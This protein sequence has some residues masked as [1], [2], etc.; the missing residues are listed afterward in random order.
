M[1]RIGSQGY[2][3]AYAYAGATSG[4]TGTTA[5]QTQAKAAEAAKSG[6]SVSVT[7]SAEAQAALAAAGSDGRS[8]STV[9]S[10]ARKSLD[11]LLSAAKATSALKDGKATIDVSGLD[12]R[13][14]Y[15]IAS[16]Q[17]GGFP[18]EEQVVAGLQLK[19]GQDKALAGP[20]ADARVA[21]DYAGLYKAALTR[22]EAAGTEEKGTLAWQSAKAALVEGLR[23][24]TAKPGTAPTGVAD[25]PVAAYL[26]EN[27]GVVSNPRSRDIDDVVSD[28]RTALDRQ[29]SLATGEGMA[30]DADAGTIDFSRFDDRSLSAVALNKGGGF[31]EHEVKEAAAEIRARSRDGVSS[32]WKSAQKSGDGSAFGRTLV[33]QYVSMSD[34][35]RE[36]AG[37][38]P[39]LYD[40]MVSLQNL[41]TRL[42]S[43][44]DADGTLKTGMSLL[45]YL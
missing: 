41:S 38:T 2:A 1:T 31:S 34:E 26:K 7:L 17:G 19:A 10:D 16:N 39:A 11:A 8:L 29:Y 20:A 13:G 14:L 9:I 23:Q 44:F 15:A 40:K 43:M 3:A 6:A 25:D 32:S 5:A 21:G 27:G 18:I 30:R 22:H 37:W 35:E 45:D 24:A 12:R 33:S 28:V 36:A 42:S 4:Q